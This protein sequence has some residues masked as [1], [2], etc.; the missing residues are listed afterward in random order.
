YAQSGPMICAFVSASSAWYSMNERSAPAAADDSPATPE[1]AVPGGL[2]PP[3][4]R[5]TKTTAARTTNATTT[6]PPTA[7]PQFF[8]RAISALFSTNACA[9]LSRHITARALLREGYSLPHTGR[10]GCRLIADKKAV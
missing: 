10:C 9:R 5:W 7:D 3:P 6:R 2:A 4:A 8:M 1:G